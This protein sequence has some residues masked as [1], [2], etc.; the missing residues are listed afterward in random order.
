V[1]PNPI[2]TGTATIL[3]QSYGGT[4]DVK[5]QIFTSG[6]KPVLT[7]TFSMVPSGQ[8]V[9]VDLVDDWGQP[10]ANNVYYVKVTV[11]GSQR[12]TSLVVAP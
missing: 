5:V 9:Q 1:F 3:P 11:G 2:T 12:T 4:Q 7:K 6:F 10:L 8:T